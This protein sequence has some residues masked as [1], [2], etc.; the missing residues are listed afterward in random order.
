MEKL[1]KSLVSDLNSVPLRRLSTDAENAY[2]KIAKDSSKPISI[3]IAA[4]NTIYKNHLPFVIACARKFASKDLPV[5]DLIN[6]G[7]L[8]LKIALKHYTP[9]REAKFMSYA[10]WWIRET[11]QSYIY[12]KRN[13][14]RIPESKQ[15]L[16]HRLNKEV[17]KT[18]N[19]LEDVADATGNTQHIVNMLNVLKPVSLDMPVGS[20]KTDT[21]DLTLGD[22]L[23]NTNL[24][25]DIE[26]KQKNDKLYSALKT[27][28]KRELT[29]IND[30]YGLE[31][32]FE[33]TLREVGASNGNSCERVRQLKNQALKRL[34]R[35][36][37]ELKYN[38]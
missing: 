37:K 16:L 23:S 2:I 25:Y 5:T 34:A 4:E 14:I 22:T 1:V 12:K 19:K 7:F 15:A 35:N 9:G 31:S 21:A 10:V 32:G 6:E 20:G 24:V 30:Y 3:R 28:P 8:G 26:S 11:I 27:L 17:R 33:K 29:I 36:L 18:N 38:S 13:L